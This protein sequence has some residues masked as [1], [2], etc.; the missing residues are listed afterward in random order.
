M[1]KEENEQQKRESID[2]MTQNKKLISIITVR[3]EHLAM[4]N[5]E[6]ETYM[7]LYDKEK[8]EHHNT[9]QALAALENRYYR[10]LE[11]REEKEKREKEK[12]LKAQQEEKDKVK[13][14]ETKDNEDRTEETTKN[15]TVQVE[16][17]EKQQ[18]PILK[19]S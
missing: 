2:I 13:E 19:L 15:V 8:G 4:L 16:K 9:A 12:L 7:L 1:L 10:E 17:E 18:Q 6:M 3:N 14:A 11:E 5:E